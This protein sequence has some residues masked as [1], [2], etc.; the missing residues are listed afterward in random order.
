LLIQAATFFV[1]L[2]LFIPFIFITTY[3][4]ASG[5]E[6]SLAFYLISI[7]NASSVFGRI[8][9]G[10]LA[11]RIGTFNVQF[12]FTSMMAISVAVWIVCT[13]TQTIILFAILYGFVSG[14]FISLFNVCCASISPIRT[15]GARYNPFYVTNKNR[16]DVDIYWI[17]LSDWD[18]AFSGMYTAG[19]VGS[20]FWSHDCG[21]WIVYCGWSWILW[22]GQS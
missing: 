7:L 9:S 21:V 17:G 16:F 13:E 3:A 4:I 15:T 18:T 8:G 12:I 1:F 2:G 14:G 6:T 10:F 5:M 20:Q 19:Y 11:D 22:G